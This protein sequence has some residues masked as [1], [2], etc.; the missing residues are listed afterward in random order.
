MCRSDEVRL[1]DWREVDLDSGIWTIPMDRSRTGREHKVPLARRDTR[2]TG[3]GAATLARRGADLSLRYRQAAFGRDAVEAGPGSRHPGGP[4]SIPV[5]TPRLV[6][7]DGPA[8]RSCRGVLGACR[9]E[10]GLGGL[11]AIGPDQSTSDPDAGLGEVSLRLSLN[12]RVDSG[13]N[14]RNHARTR[15]L[16]R[17]STATARSLAVV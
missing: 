8:A 5:L 2:R 10:Q 3:R 12:A 9:Q 6:R 4:A 15:K 1:S 17:E 7:G 16:C 13:R 14:C 11:R